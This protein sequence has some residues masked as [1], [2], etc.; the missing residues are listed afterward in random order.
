MEAGQK[1]DGTINQ[2]NPNRKSHYQNLR[3][4]QLQKQFLTEANGAGERPLTSGRA[5][6]PADF[7]KI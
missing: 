3:K 5:F 2:T 7:P 1:P 6:L 4:V